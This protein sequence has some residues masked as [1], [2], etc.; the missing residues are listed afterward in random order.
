MNFPTAAVEDE[1]EYPLIY[2]GN[3]RG[4][5][6]KEIRARAIW[7]AV[8]FLPGDYVLF[9]RFWPHH[10]TPSGGLYLRYSC[11]ISAFSRVCAL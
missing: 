8:T 10:K 4:E 1:L 2:L 9:R 11:A 7:V 3:L 6:K 5:G